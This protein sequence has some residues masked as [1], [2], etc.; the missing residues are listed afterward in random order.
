VY[1]FHGAYDMQVNYELSKQYFELL[2][3]PEKHF[4]TFENSAHS[5]FMEEPQRFIEIVIRDVLGLKE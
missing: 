2:N 5:P 3:A 1:I 4:Y